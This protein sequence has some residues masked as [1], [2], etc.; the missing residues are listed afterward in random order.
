MKLI[1]VIMREFILLLI[2]I[3]MYFIGSESFYSVC[4]FICFYEL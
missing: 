4:Y 1:V 2:F 3:R